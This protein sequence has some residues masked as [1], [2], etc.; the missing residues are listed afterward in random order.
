M[1]RLSVGLRGHSRAPGEFS[2]LRIPYR[3][4]CQD[5]ESKNSHTY[6]R[7]H[8]EGTCNLSDGLVACIGEA[9]RQ[10]IA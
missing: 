6:S 4:C 5:R 9:A 3:V 8:T 7:Y 2:L 1:L 10:V